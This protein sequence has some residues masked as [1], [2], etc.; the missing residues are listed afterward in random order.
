MIFVNSKDLGS[1]SVNWKIKNV[2]L[3]MENNRKV[4]KFP[5]LLCQKTPTY[6]FKILSHHKNNHLA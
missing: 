2:G 5:H 4:T 6:N 3:M 1:G